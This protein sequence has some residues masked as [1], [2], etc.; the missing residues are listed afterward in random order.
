MVPPTRQDSIDRFIESSLDLF[1][2][3]D[4]ETEGVIDRI[5]KIA[6][7]AKRLTEGTVKGFGLNAG[8]YRTLVHL[9]VAPDHQRAAGDL[10]EKL[11]LSTG[12]MTN[13]LDGLEEQ[14]LVTRERAVAD[15]RSVLVTLTPKGLETLIQ[16][17]EAVA[18]EESAL[19]SE[20]TEAQRRQLNGLLRC[21]VLA[22]EDTEA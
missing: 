16:A 20:L 11:D 9:R 10:A 6:R 18:A 15:R 7:H 2:G 21:L 12:A 14:G 19:L 1:P 5:L 4:A 8:E 22:A 13:R 17:V 3:V